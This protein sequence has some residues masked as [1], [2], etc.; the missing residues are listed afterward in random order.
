MYYT[1]KRRTIYVR[2]RSGI[3]R[4]REGREGYSCTSLKRPPLRAIG[5]Q[6]PEG[7]VRC[8]PRQNP[9]P[10]FPGSRIID[11]SRIQPRYTCFKI[12]SVTC[13]YKFYKFSF[14]VVWDKDSINLKI[15]VLGFYAALETFF[16]FF[17]FF[18]LPSF[19]L[20]SP[21]GFYF[22]FL[23]LSSELEETT[24]RKEKCVKIRRTWPKGESR[25]IKVQCSAPSCFRCAAPFQNRVAFFGPVETNRWCIVSV[26]FDRSLNRIFF[27]NNLSRRVFIFA[28]FRFYF[29]IFN[30]SS[31]SIINAFSI[32][33][34]V[35]IL[36]S[37][38]FENS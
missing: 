8:A 6:H 16:F 12:K 33:T 29:S 32:R 25:T 37:H 30:A 31:F 13:C 20:F 28:M 24:S 23:S 34:I 22:F 21:L 26:C 3:A 4:T 17:F 36:L 5:D 11:T 18:L 19:P 7:I 9:L 15:F 35:H 2:T 10:F 1:W 27:E 14:V 38:K